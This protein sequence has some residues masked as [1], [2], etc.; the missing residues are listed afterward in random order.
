MSEIDKTQHA[1]AEEIATAIGKSK[2]TAERMAA[3]QKWP[4]SIEKTRGFSKKWFLIA[5]LPRD[6]RGK[7]NYKRAIK[8]MDAD[9]AM[10]ALVAPASQTVKD[11]APVQTAA[12]PAV[13]PPMPIDLDDSQRDR[14][15]ARQYILNFISQFDGSI[16]KAVRALNDDYINGLCSPDMMRAI[17]TCNDKQKRCIV[18]V[19]TVEKWKKLKKRT[20]SCAPKK[21]RIPTQF[22]AIPWLPLFLICYRKPQ[23]PSLRDAHAEL[24]KVWQEAGLNGPAPSYDAVWRAVQKVP[25]VVLETGRSSGSELAA[26]KAFVRRDWSGA[27]NEVWV[28]DGHTFKAKVRHPEHGQPFAPEVTVIIDAASRFIVG[29]AFSLSENQLAVSE[30]LGKGMMKHGKPLIYYSDNGAGQTAKIID[31]PVGG[32][33]ARLGVHHET[34]IP[35]NPQGRGLIEGLWDITTIWAAKQMPTFQGTGMDDGA[36]RKNT[37]AINSAKTKGLVPTFVPS[38]QAFMDACVARFEW[39]NTQHKHTSLGGKTPAEVYHA[40]FD[41]SWA[42]PLTYDEQLNLFRPS[43]ERTPARG[44]IKW[45][46]NIYFNPQLVELPANTKVRM[47]YDLDNAERVWVSDLKG[48]FICEAEF[49]ANKRDGFAK[50]LKD[51]L[52]DQRID[53]KVKRAQDKIDQA[54]AEKGLTIE[55][56]VLHRVPVIPAEPVEPLKRLVMDSGINRSEPE[57]QPMSYLDTVRM[58]KRAGE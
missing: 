13:K 58:L 35:G 21:T 18:S 2:S 12:V 33:L 32:M 44:E 24:G 48:R 53:G 38:W 27:S 47:S 1:D 4:H 40:N 54:N 50:S 42:C 56:E 36:I 51:A 19:S 37:Q 20:G 49:E 23:K 15:G 55:G 52:K 8:A 26:L 29:W 39:Y 6:I 46:N 3:K 25:R 14:D 28:G 9:P 11:V 43:V 7:V 5:Q 31:D 45:L 10:K 41:A 30:A 22:Q 34:G 16:A 57:E 17:E